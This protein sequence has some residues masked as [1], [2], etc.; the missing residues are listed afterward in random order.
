M[1]EIIK[2]IEHEQL[3]DDVKKFNVGDTIKV[4]YR[5][6]EGTRERVQVFEGTVIK[7]QGS[8]AKKLLLLEDFLMA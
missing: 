7:I 3:K 8:G 2:S 1:Q 6:I 4:H 5:I